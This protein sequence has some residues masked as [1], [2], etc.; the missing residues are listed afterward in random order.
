MLYIMVIFSVH[1]NPAFTHPLH[2]KLKDVPLPDTLLLETSMAAL[3]R[4]TLLPP[5]Q[6]QK[7]ILLQ[8]A[9]DLVL[10]LR[11]DQLLHTAGGILLQL[12]G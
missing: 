8:L 11:R 12:M 1:H 7:V 4:T 2:L 10:L 6:P 3:P 9:K 5:Q